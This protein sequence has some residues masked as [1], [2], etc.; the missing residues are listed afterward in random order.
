MG[1]SDSILI[2]RQSHYWNLYLN[3]ISA[4]INIIINININ[5]NYLL[6]KNSPLYE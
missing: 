1:R 4:I 2:I 6:Y 5:I 3:R